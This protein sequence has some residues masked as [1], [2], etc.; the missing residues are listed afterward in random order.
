MGHAL[1]IAIEV[2]IIGDK[3]A[4]RPGLYAETFPNCPRLRPA[5]RA[6]YFGWAVT[7]K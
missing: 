2:P 1:P 3:G 7:R 4:D 5:S 6:G